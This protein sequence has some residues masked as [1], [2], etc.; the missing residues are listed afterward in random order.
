MTPKKIEERWGKPVMDRIWD[1]M[2]GLPVHVLIE[3]ILLRMPD[4]EIEVWAS[5]ITKENQ[6]ETNND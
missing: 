1:Q 4:A 6:N 2:L 5:N 3:Q